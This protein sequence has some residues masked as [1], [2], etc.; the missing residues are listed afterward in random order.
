MKKLLDRQTLAEYLRYYANRRTSFDRVFKILS[1]DY[2]VEPFKDVWHLVENNYNFLVDV[3]EVK[4]QRH[5][6]L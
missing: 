1:R 2:N 6:K 5:V 4:Q 3:K